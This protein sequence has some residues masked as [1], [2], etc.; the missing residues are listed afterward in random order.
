MK[1]L[2]PSPRAGSRT[3]KHQQKEAQAPEAAAQTLGL[4]V[5]RLEL[6][7]KPWPNFCEAFNTEDEK[8]S[9]AEKGSTLTQS[10]WPVRG[11]ASWAGG[12]ENPFMPLRLCE[13]P[14]VGIRTIA[15]L[16][17]SPE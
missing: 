11:N 8:H 4:F 12:G 3:A 14:P 15:L 2:L 16:L 9:R 7:H 6:L 5:T 10:A 17:G 1:K 13:Q